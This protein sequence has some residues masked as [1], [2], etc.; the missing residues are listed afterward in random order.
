MYVNKEIDYWDGKTWDG[1]ENTYSL[2]KEIT[3]DQE[4]KLFNYIS[5]NKKWSLHYNCAA[6]AVDAWNATGLV[7]L[8]ATGVNV[9]MLISPLLAYT[10]PHPDH[11]IKSVKKQSGYS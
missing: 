10:W 2:T 6:F 5:K 4:K 1:V 7:K 11:L 8:S 3:H 9:W